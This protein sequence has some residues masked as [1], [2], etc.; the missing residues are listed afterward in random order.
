NNI[1]KIAGKDLIR[2]DIALEPYAYSD[3][4]PARDENAWASYPLWQDNAY[5]PDF[6]IGHIVPG[7]SNFS[8]VAKITPYSHVDNYVGAQKLLDMYLAQGSTVKFRYYLKTNQQV[9]FLK[10]RF[11]AGKYGKIDFTISHPETNKWIWATVNFN[12]F[13]HQNP[14]I[15][16]KNKIRIYAL[17]FLAKIPKA[18]PAMPVYLGLDD[19]TFRGEREIPFHFIEPAMYKL[20]EFE[21]YIP[22]HP[23]YSGD[24]F[25]LA[26]NYPADAKKVILTIAPFTDRKEIIYKSELQKKEKKW[27]L[28]P[29]KLS[30]QEGLYLGKLSAYNGNKVLSETEFTIH[31]AQKNIGDVHPRLLFNKSKLSEITEQIKEKDFYPVNDSIVVWASRLRSEIPAQSLVFDLDQFPDKNWLPSWTAFGDHIYNTGTALRWNAFTYAFDGDTVAGDYVKNIL[32]RLS[33][34]PIWTSPWLIKHGIYDDHRMGT[35]STDVALA[36]D[37]TYHLMTPDERTRIREAIIKNII[38][39]CFRTWVYNNYVTSN[40]SNWIAHT[41]GGALMN[42][43]AMYEDGRKTQDMEPYFT[44]LTMKF[45]DYITHVTDTIG[46]AWGEGYGYNNYSFSNM[47]YSVPSLQNVFNID[48]SYPL[49]GTYKEYVWSGLIKDRKWFSYGDSDDSL[50][51]ADN[52]A[53]MLSKYKKPLLSWF[54]NYLKDGTTLNDILFDTKGIPQ[55]DPF[56]EDPDRVFPM[57]GTT[58]FKSGWSKKDFVFVMRTGAFFNHQHLDQGSFYLA[59]HGVTFIEDQPIKNSDYYKDPLYQSNFTQ[60]VAHSTILIDHNAQSQRVGDPL[61]FASGFDD[62]AFIEQYLDGKDAAFSRGNI[63]RLYWGKVKSLTRNVLYIK[64]GVILML[65]VAVPAKNNADVTLLY[66]TK[67]LKDIRP[68]EKASEITIDGFTLHIMHLSPDSVEVKAV[69]TPHFLN[70]L[71]NEKPLIKEGMLTVTARTHNKPLVMANLFTTSVAGIKPDVITKE[72]NGFVSGEISGRKFAFSTNPGHKYHWENIQ[73]DALAITVSKTDTLAAM[74]TILNKDNI[75][76]LR[77][78]QP[79]TFDI[80]NKGLTFYCENKEKLFIYR[81]NKPSIVTLNGE[82]IKKFRYNLREKWVEITIPKG[83]GEIILN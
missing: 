13:I 24:I 5:D 6:R 15:A 36:Y 81:D 7:D 82:V 70:A 50:V 52:W 20:P 83:K 53:F 74:A 25:K 41:V 4:F 27:I 2:E 17:A 67:D 29:V 44:G 66:H 73:T 78:E 71:L 37:L 32:L 11:A 58:V 45:Y 75:T 26:G 8:I 61:N 33:S 77:S 57:V 54:Y 43:A 31:I 60:P 76:F 12:D 34:W 47:M 3:S 21:P 51:S 48:L 72:G 63:G 62:H 16:G 59:D 39:G 23:Y 38:K 65:D 28:E 9:A 49:I 42:L 80:S 10:V 19:I 46:G 68:G 22:K 14:V 79:A 55:K 18:D 64:P 56:N 40:T 30:F 69:E 1:T 35:W